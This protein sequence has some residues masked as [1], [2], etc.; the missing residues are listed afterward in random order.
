M[1]HETSHISERFCAPDA[2]M[3]VSSCDDVLFNLHRKNLEVHSAIL[4]NAGNAE[5]DEEPIHLTES[6][7][8]LDL[9]F[10]FMYPQPQPDLKLVEFA[11]VAALAEAAEKYVVYSALGWC[12]E[13][14]SKSMS[15]HPLEVLLYSVRHGHVDL[16]NKSAQQSMSCEFTKAMEVLPPDTFKT[17]ILFYDRWNREK[18][19]FLMSL[20]QENCHNKQIRLMQ[21]CFGCPNPFRTFRKDLE[22]FGYEDKVKAML[23]I[24]FMTEASAKSNVSEH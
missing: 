21:K 4:A 13:R 24:K 11:T 19:E 8:V 2:D 5:N 20:A 22:H 16:A 23:E 9:L 17:W 1:A 12:R 15:E 10:Q 6:S 14:M 18:V 3:T 7:N